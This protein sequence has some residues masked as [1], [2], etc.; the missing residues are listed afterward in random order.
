[1]K[2]YLNLLFLGLGVCSCS[3]LP[4]K[5]FQEEFSD[6]EEMVDRLEDQGAFMSQSLDSL[7]HFYEDQIARFDSLLTFADY[8]KYL[9][10]GPFSTATPGLDST[11]SSIIILNTTSDREQALQEVAATNFLDVHFAQFVKRNELVAQ[12]YSNSALQVSRVYPCYDHKNIVDP[13]IDV[14]QFNFY[15][16]ANEINNPN[17]GLVWIP[18]AYVDPAGRGWIVSLVHP[19]Y[20]DNSLFAVLGVDFT[21]DDVI[22]TYLQDYDGEYLLVNAKGDI[23]AGK[24]GAIETISMPPLKNHVYR[25]TVKSENFRVS[26]FNLFQSRSK[27]VRK[28]AQEFLLNKKKVFEFNEEK[29]LKVA[30][31]LP[32]EEIDWYM[33]QIIPNS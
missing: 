21:V 16:A 29:N 15:Y 11:K 4:Q 30:L 24:A 20:K 3:F 17:K 9:I 23:V 12:V 1:M 8:D 22:Y 25:E 18:D 5:S 14:T 7:A 2:N 31:C 33:I 28:M 13:N 26:D 32:F 6:L 27:E 10:E 19:I